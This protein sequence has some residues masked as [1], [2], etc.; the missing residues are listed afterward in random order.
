[1][2]VQHGQ[3]RKT[4]FNHC[5]DKAEGAEDGLGWRN[6]ACFFRNIRHLDGRIERGEDSTSPF[7]SLSVGIHGSRVDVAGEN[8][9]ASGPRGR[10]WTPS[11]TSDYFCGALD[12]VAFKEEVAI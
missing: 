7:L 5:E 1:M 10:T 3:R 4:H 8:V 9:A 2:I 11:E 12:E 6:A